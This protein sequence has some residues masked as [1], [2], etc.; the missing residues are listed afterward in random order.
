MG[1]NGKVVALNLAADKPAGSRETCLSTS[2]NSIDQAFAI[3][4]STTMYLCLIRNEY[5]WREGSE[6]AIRG[7]EE[8]EGTR[9]GLEPLLD[10]VD[11]NQIL[12]NVLQQW[13]SPS[14]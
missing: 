1:Q 2:A 14:H 7:I 9:D 3:G 10:L 13:S 4:P 11:V 8:A 12:S 5:P 6:A